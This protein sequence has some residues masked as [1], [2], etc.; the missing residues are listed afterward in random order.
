MHEI[1]KQ[2]REIQ[3]LHRSLSDGEL[4][5][6]ID[7]YTPITIHG[8][9]GSLSYSYSQDAIEVS[10]WFRLDEAFVDAMYGDS[11]EQVLRELGTLVELWLIKEIK[12]D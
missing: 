7:T 1:I 9:T 3:R 11:E 4:G 5:G 10:F 12:D 2:I 6:N 8:E